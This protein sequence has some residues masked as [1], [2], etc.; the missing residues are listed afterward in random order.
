MRSIFL[1]L[2]AFGLFSC[3]AR[4]VISERQPQQVGGVIGSSSPK[5]GTT[6]AKVD[7]NG[8]VITDFHVYGSIQPGSC[9]IKGKKHYMD[10]EYNQAVEEFQKTQ[11]PVH[12]NVSYVCVFEVEDFAQKPKNWVPNKFIDKK[13]YT[14]ILTGNI[15]N[16]KILK[17]FAGEKVYI[18]TRNFVRIID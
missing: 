9:F 1:S 13:T 12:L 4:E 14:N 2:I 8:N 3:A 5:A 10:P 15:I 7:D 18:N 17:M 6:E 16:T 11:V